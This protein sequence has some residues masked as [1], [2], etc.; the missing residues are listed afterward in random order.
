MKKIIVTTAFGAREANANEY[1][2]RLEP[3][4]PSFEVEVNG[5]KCRARATSGKGK[6]TINNHYFYF[7][8]GDQMYYVRSTPDEIAKLKAGEGT[9]TDKKEEV[10]ATDTPVPTPPAAEVVQPTE[11][12]KKR[13]AGKAKETA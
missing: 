13:R 5:V 2:M 4:S 7:I 12:P 6:S 1:P 10:A 8:E 3:K 11:A 9:I